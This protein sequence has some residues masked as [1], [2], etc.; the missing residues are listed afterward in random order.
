MIRPAGLRTPDHW[1]R[2]AERPLNA[3]PLAWTSARRRMTGETRKMPTEHDPVA[4]AVFA[5]RAAPPSDYGTTPAMYARPESALD[6]STEQTGG[7]S[8]R[9]LPD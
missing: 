6:M 7:L 2:A 4:T 5:S 3:F 9:P 8:G 1:Q